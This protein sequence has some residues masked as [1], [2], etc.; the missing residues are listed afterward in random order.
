MSKLIVK[1]LF[2]LCTI[3]LGTNCRGAGLL[4]KEIHFSEQEIQA[5]IDKNGVTRKSYGKG[6]AVVA[7]LE[8][9]RIK[10]GEPPGQV[11]VNARLD[12]ALFGGAPV[13]VDIE[14]NSGLRYDDAAKAFFLDRPVARSVSSGA[15]TPETEPMARQAITQL[16][17]AYFRDK[18]VYVLR[19]D[20]SL[21]EK[22]ARWLLRDIR[23][24]PGRVTAVLS[25]L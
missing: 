19:E 5:R 7:L 12:V 18:P 10:L 21:E 14:G 11:T 1:T 13:P 4:E 23:I 22:A 6:L 24:E 2:L 20:G 9:P 3:L 16:L 15:L 17:A 25:P 8:P